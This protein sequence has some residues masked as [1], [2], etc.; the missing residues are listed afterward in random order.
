MEQKENSKY[1]FESGNLLVFLYKWR[2]PLIIISLVGAII[3]AGVS[4]LID[5]K[6]KSTVIMFPTSTNSI[7]KALLAE[8]FGGKDDILQFGEEEQAEQLLQ[9]LNSDQIRQ[10]IIRK[11]NLMRHYEIDTTEKFR[12]TKLMKEYESNISFERTEFMSVKVEVLDE[13]PDTAA[14]IANDIAALLDSVKNRMRKDLAQEAFE[15]VKDEYFELRDYIH[16]REDSLKKLRELGVYDYESQAERLTE[17]WGKAV[18]QNNKRAINELE[19]RLDV[20][21]KYGGAYVAIRD[22][23]EYDKKQLS[24]LRAKYEE[25]QVD[26]QRSLEHKFIVDRAYAAEKKSYPIRWLIV[27]VST[28]ATFIITLFSILIVESIKKIKQAN[29]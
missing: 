9:I 15:I 17:Q 7:S 6:Y 18:L 4:L 24:F 27:V 8:N 14:M 1:Q 5:N 3:S 10:R 11:Y 19:E 22:N 16:A 28:L 20:L 29:K 13:S 25:A 21:A 2:K 26:A 23:L 12:K